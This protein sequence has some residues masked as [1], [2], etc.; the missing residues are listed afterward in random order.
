MV[1]LQ[2]RKKPNDSRD[3]ARHMEFAGRHDI[4]SILYL[5]AIKLNKSD[6]RALGQLSKLYFRVGLPAAA[7]HHCELYHAALIESTDLVEEEMLSRYA[8]VHL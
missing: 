8:S 7:L 3:T 6:W 4:A 5:E 1:G 2:I